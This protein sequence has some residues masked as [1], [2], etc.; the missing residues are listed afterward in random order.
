MKKHVKLK[1]TIM[2]GLLALN[3]VS[4]TEELKEA[5][6]ENEAPQEG[7]Q[8]GGPPGG[9]QGQEGYDPEYARAMENNFDGYQ[10][11]QGENCYHLQDQYAQDN[12]NLPARRPMQHDQN[13]YSNQYGMAVDGSRIQ[14]NQS[15]FQFDTSPNQLVNDRGADR[16]I[17]VHRNGVPI[18]ARYAS[19]YERE[20]ELD[21]N[22]GRYGA[23]KDFPRGVYHYVITL[24]VNEI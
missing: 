16:M 18:Y 24:N 2:V 8:Q 14:R 10:A 9:G 11:Q 6:S 17:G 21:Q 1:S 5:I 19:P 20:D 13:S 3:M 4:C 15:G 12:Y 23:T 7:Q 22:G